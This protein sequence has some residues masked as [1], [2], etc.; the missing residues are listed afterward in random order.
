MQILFLVPE[1]NAD[2]FSGGLLTVLEYAN[3]LSRKG[4]DVTVFPIAKS[5]TPKW[6]QPE[7]NIVNASFQ[8]PSLS[9]VLKAL[10]KD[11]MSIRA[12]LTKALN[13]FSPYGSYTY[14]RA[15]QL[16]RCRDLPSADISIAT[17][18]ESVLPLFLYGAGEK[19][20]FAQ[21]FEPYFASERENPVLAER[22]AILTY[23]LPGIKIIANSTWL[24]MRLAEILKKEVRV[25]V[26]AIDHNIF[27]PYSKI[28]R[29]S[30][31]F[32][33]ISYGG[34]KAQWKGIEEMAKAVRIAKRSIPHIEWHVFGDSLLPPKNDL[35][36]YRSLGFIS[37]S[38]LRLA[39]IS[40][41]VMLCGSWYESFRCFLWK[42]WLVAFL[43]YPQKAGVE[44][45]MHHLRNG[46]VVGSSDPILMAEA[47]I[48][49]APEP[50][51]AKEYRITIKRRC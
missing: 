45:Y 26:N 22:D 17:S 38:D 43:S 7:F 37:G 31:R 19:Y 36:E 48:D 29:N 23:Y 18:Y 21:H 33:V 8:R 1:I 50:R 44:D 25:C 34:R 49:F 35:A 15:S 14:Q 40:A 10:R 2:K 47:L 12:V 16:E 6:F 9:V 28:E 11:I 41:D 32:V 30:E 4:H 51:N 13:F 46:Y 27:F 39:Y 42:P 5:K 20:Y 24:S 3:G